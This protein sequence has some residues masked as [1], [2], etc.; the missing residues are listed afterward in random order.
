MASFKLSRW[1][2][3][4]TCDVFGFRTPFRK[5]EVPDAVSSISLD[6]VR[7]LNCGINFDLVWSASRYDGMPK[8][9]VAIESIL[10]VPL[11]SVDCY[12]IIPCFFS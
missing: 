3:F 2:N 11:R 5:E 8:N 7:G 10:F 4:L 9:V 12:L 6:F 1:V